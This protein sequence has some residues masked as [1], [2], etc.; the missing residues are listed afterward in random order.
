MLGSSSMI[1]CWV[2]CSKLDAFVDKHGVLFVIANKITE[3]DII[4]K[5]SILE[6]VKIGRK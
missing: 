4:F 5:V 3:T 6:T 2:D 1:E